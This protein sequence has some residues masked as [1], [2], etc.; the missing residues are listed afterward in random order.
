MIRQNYTVPKFLSEVVSYS[1]S[2]SIYR[3]AIQHSIHDAR[4]PHAFPWTTNGIECNYSLCLRNG[5]WNP[6]EKEKNDW[7]LNQWKRNWAIILTHVT[8]QWGVGRISIENIH[9]LARAIHMIILVLELLVAGVAIEHFFASVRKEV[10]GPVVSWHCL[11]FFAKRTECFDF[12]RVYVE[13]LHH[14]IGT[15]SISHFGWHSSNRNFE[16]KKK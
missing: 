11:C 3:N 2:A 13:L 15:K 5:E 14:V 16:G 4:S 12:A 7:I 9:H 10:H 6:N 1:E 8:H